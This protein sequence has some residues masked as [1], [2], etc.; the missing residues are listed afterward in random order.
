MNFK[1][2]PRIRESRKCLALAWIFFFT[3]LAAIMLLSYLLGTKPYLWGLP[4]WVAVGNIIIPVVFVV[5]LIVVSEKFIGD[6]VLT[7]PDEKEERK[8]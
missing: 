7:D 6:T 4:R 3:Y 5:L 8:E 1:E 2:D